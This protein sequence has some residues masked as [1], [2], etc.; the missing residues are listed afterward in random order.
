MPAAVDS[1]G[2]AEASRQLAAPSAV[3]CLPTAALESRAPL[4]ALLR[5]SALASFQ[6]GAP[7]LG[8]PHRLGQALRACPHA[9]QG[10]TATIIFSSSSEKNKTVVVA[11]EGTV[12]A[13]AQRSSKAVWESR[14]NALRSRRAVRPSSSSRSSA[15]LFQGDGGQ[16]VGGRQGAKLAAS[17]TAAHWLST[18]AGTAGTVPDQLRSQSH[19]DVA[20]RSRARNAHSASALPATTAISQRFYPPFRTVM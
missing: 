7:W 14:G 8:S 4:L 1:H 19:H 3:P 15:R 12:W 5:G 9:P 2:T 11:R 10:A 13:S 6:A 17:V 16:A 18:G 20:L